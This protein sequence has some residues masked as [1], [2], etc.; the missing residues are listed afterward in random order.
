MMLLLQNWPRSNYNSCIAQ[1]YKSPAAKQPS[2]KW[3]HQD[4]ND[5]LFRR[6]IVIIPPTA[7][8][9]P[10]AVKTNPAKTVSLAARVRRELSINIS[11]PITFLSSV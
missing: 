2:T 10:T 6:F 9:N 3:V 7:W 5:S 4:N 1:R 8:D 11:S